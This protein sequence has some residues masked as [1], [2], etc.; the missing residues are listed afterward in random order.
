MALEFQQ[1]DQQ[2]PIHQFFPFPMAGV[3]LG[4]PPGDITP[5]RGGRQATSRRR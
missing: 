1:T 3:A 2:N 4:E 5:A